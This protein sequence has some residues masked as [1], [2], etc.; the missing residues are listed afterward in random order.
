MLSARMIPTGGRLIGMETKRT[1][2][3]LDSFQVGNNKQR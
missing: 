3:W 1:N 2:L